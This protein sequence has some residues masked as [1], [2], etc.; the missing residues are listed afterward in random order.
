MSR[1]LVGIAQLA[2]TLAFALPVALLGLQMLASGDALWGGS[3]LFVAAGMVAVEEYL[4]T[5]GDV[6]SLLFER[7]VGTVAEA[8]EDEE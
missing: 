3:F 8:P 2:V 5:P 4:T 1:G 7:V 6:P